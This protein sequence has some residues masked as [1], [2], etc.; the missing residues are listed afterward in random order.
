MKIVHSG[1]IGGERKLEDRALTERPASGPK[2]LVSGP[3]AMELLGGPSLSPLPIKVLSPRPC[4]VVSSSLN[5]G[6]LT[7]TSFDTSSNEFVS[8][9]L[10]KSSEATN[11]PHYGRLDLLI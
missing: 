10:V 3:H 1:V 2:S 8:L 7:G 5:Q 4:F 6:H 11:P 9:F